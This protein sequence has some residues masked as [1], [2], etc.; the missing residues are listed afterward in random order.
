MASMWNLG[1]LTPLQLAK[2][3][4]KHVDNDDVS[5]RAAQLAYYALLALFPLLIFLISLLGYFSGPGSQLRQALLDNL[6]R[7]MPGSA[8]DLVHKTLDQV[9]RSRGSGKLILGLIGALWAASAGMAALIATLNVAYHVKE[10][11][12]WWKRR[13][14]AI[15]LT[16]AVSVLVIVSLVLVLYGGRLA[17]FISS[18]VGLGDTFV[19]V[20]R[21]VQWPAVLVVMLL[22]FGLIYYFGPAVKNRRWHWMSPG[23]VAALTLW[24]LGTFAFRV[25][26]NYFNSYGATYGS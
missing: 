16:I 26:L 4:A 2:N 5:G 25:Y 6:S 23:A 11:R 3:V 9:F 19:L 14:I 24:L 15:A 22:A 1:G 20:W 8:S 10:T 17:L 12:A 13:L 18:H 21:I 7:V